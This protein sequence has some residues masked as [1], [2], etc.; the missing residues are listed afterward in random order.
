MELEARLEMMS[1]YQALQDD[2]IE[3]LKVRAG[4][5]EIKTEI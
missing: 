3:R 1:Q 2:F 4:M 5:L